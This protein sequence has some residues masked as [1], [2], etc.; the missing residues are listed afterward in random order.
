MHS[1]VFQGTGSSWSHMKIISVL[2]ENISVAITLDFFVVRWIK[3]TPIDGERERERNYSHSCILGSSEHDGLANASKSHYNASNLRTTVR[4]V[5]RRVLRELCIFIRLVKWVTKGR[6]ECGGETIVLIFSKII[7]I[8]LNGIFNVY[9]FCSRHFGAQFSNALIE[10][11]AA[12]TPQQH[13]TAR[14]S[15]HCC[16]RS[17]VYFVAACT[18]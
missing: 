14:V 12:W 15:S 1:P 3:I 17:S 5:N 8:Q 2:S 16:R 18:P 9:R 11:F 4:L 10:H 13:T 7:I 6:N